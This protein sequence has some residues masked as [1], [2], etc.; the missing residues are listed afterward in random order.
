MLAAV[1]KCWQRSRQAHVTD[2]NIVYGIPLLNTPWMGGEATAGQTFAM[3]VE[4]QSIANEQAIWYGEE[5]FDK[6]IDYTTGG[7]YASATKY[8]TS[9]FVEGAKC[10]PRNAEGRVWFIWSTSQS[11]IAS[12][13]SWAKPYLTMEVYESYETGHTRMGHHGMEPMP[14]GMNK[15]ILFGKVEEVFHGIDFKDIWNLEDLFIQADI[16]EATY[17]ICGFHV[18]GACATVHGG[19]FCALDWYAQTGGMRHANPNEWEH[20]LILDQVSPAESYKAESM[21]KMGDLYT[22]WQGHKA[23]GQ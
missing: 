8:K 1:K 20:Y 2:E 5:G 16:V 23:G 13:D 19:K 7:M 12:R 11:N 17:F 14:G 22:G 10:I 21:Q 4:Q 18:H 6:V 9:Y 15:A 3:T